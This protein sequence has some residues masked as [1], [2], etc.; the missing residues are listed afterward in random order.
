[1]Q[2][3]KTLSANQ[4]MEKMLAHSPVVSRNNETFMKSN[5]RTPVER[6]LTFDQMQEFN[7]LLGIRPDRSKTIAESSRDLT[8]TLNNR[9]SFDMIA[10]HKVSAI[11][12]QAAVTE[13]RYREG[14]MR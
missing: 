5:K 12:F 2:K 9:P 13:R 10:T 4:S 11:P 3:M 14:N 6:L 8:L 1:M 7:R